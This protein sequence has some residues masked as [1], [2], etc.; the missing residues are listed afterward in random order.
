MLDGLDA[1]NRIALDLKGE[2]LALEGFDAPLTVMACI[3]DDLSAG[4]TETDGN[5][6]LRPE[7]VRRSAARACGHRVAIAEEIGALVL[8]PERGRIGGEAGDMG[9]VVPVG[10]HASGT[11]TDDAFDRLLQVFD[12]RRSDFAEGRN[13]SVISYLRN[14]R[15]TERPE[16]TPPAARSAEIIPFCAA[17]GD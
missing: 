2:T 7:M 13:G 8:R 1:V 9:N 14:L 16:T 6:R 10:T 15:R 5:G 4:T 3:L 11:V 12:A 17:V